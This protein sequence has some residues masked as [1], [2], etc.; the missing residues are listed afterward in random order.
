LHFSTEKQKMNDTL[1][2]ILT[3]F[4]KPLLFFSCL[5]I[6]GVLNTTSY[7]GFSFIGLF[8]LYF[9]FT[10]IKVYKDLKREKV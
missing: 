2:K 1:K 10:G 4:S 8:I 7:I 6:F 5:L 3:E 9:T